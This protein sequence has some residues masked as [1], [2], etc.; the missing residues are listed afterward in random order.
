MVTEGAVARSDDEGREQGAVER[1]VDS[2]SEELGCETMRRDHS[3]QV[4]PSSVHIDLSLRCT[5]I[6][7]SARNAPHGDSQRTEPVH[8]A[9]R[10][11]TRNVRELERV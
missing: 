5:R 4:P 9:Q 11:D 1:Q 2:L 3:K 10:K 8:N 6:V 7:V